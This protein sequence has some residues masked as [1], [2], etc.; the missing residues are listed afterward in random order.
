M[1][2]SEYFVGEIKLNSLLFW[3]CKNVLKNILRRDLEIELID[4]NLKHIL[5]NEFK[6]NEN[7]INT[8]RKRRLER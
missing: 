1:L 4:E 5:K 3:K 7:I 6:I 2:F 8:K